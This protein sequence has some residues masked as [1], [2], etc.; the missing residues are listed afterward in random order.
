MK[1]IMSFLKRLVPKRKLFR[2][3][4]PLILIIAIAAAVIIIRFRASSNNRRETDPTMGLIETVSTQDLSETVTASGTVLLNDEIEVYA[5]GD[6]NIVR[7]ILVEEGDV[8]TAGDLLVEYDIDDTKE[9][10]ENSIR[11][12]KRDIESAELSLQSLSLAA[13]GSDLEKFQD[14][15]TTAEI[16]LQNANVTYNGYTT[17]LSQQQTTIDTT[18]TD[19]DRAQKD[20]DNC[21]ALMEVG[22]ATQSELD[23]CE[24]ALTNAKDTLTK[25]Q[26]DYNDLLDEQESAR[27]S[28]LS[29]ENSLSE[30]QTALYE[31]QNPLSSESS[32]ISYKQQQLNIE[33]LKDSLSDY[34]QDL[35]ELVYYTYADVS[36]TVTEV[37]I[38]E[39]TYTEENTI[40][41][42]VADFNDLIVSANI[43]E[44][45]AP[46]LALGQKVTMT[47]DGLEDKVYTGTI[48]KI[49]PSADD[50]STNMG[51]ETTVPIEISVDNP[52]G[53]L[54]PGYSLDL[55][56]T[57]SE[58]SDL[59]MISTSSISRDEN[60][61]SFVYRINNENKLEKTVITTGDSSDV[62]IEVLSGLSEGDRIVSSIFDGIEE[63][64]TLEEL[65]ELNS[66]RTAEI[67]AESKA[68]GNEN[69]GMNND[70]NNQANQMLPSGGFGG[71]SP[72]GGGPMGR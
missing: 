7:S 17:K 53:I 67:S 52:D 46:L 34:E 25:A 14:A 71:G 23:D 18:Q 50:T 33:A 56:I 62:Y 15:V 69:G 45:D 37:C 58:M 70:R 64:M 61:E 28:V 21:L 30:A 63:G 60:D 40:I 8:V 31:G 27:L 4:I 57:V 1:K 47:S 66:A 10:L 59:L 2:I 72:Q 29:A 65:I 41:M 36:G 42:Y 49:S 3:L 26:D 16:N 22:G 6:V 5:E 44:Y 11:D 9:S 48:I 13:T 24:Y 43:E 19:V 55:E 32:Q 20:Y 39:G 38:D 54:K 12:L 35:A 51:T 68:A